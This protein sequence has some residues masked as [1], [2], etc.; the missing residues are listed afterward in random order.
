MILCEFIQSLTCKPDIICLTEARIE[1]QP[2]TNLNLP[3]YHFTYVS[4]STNAGGVA[5]YISD[6]LQFNLSAEQYVLAGAE[7]LWITLYRTKSSTFKQIIIGIIYRHPNANKFKFLF[8]LEY[9][10]TK[11]SLDN[12]D[13]FIIGDININ[14]SQTGRTSSATDH[15]NLV[16]SFGGTFLITKPTRVTDKTSS[17]IYLIITNDTQHRLQS[18][19][20]LSDISDHYP[21]IQLLARLVTFHY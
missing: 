14:I 15:V 8:D 18:G 16:H 12:N 10:L 6:N 4:P 11:L 19:V 2:L 21:S 5:A 7:F 3:N 13:F 9:C 20:I 17:L 1:H